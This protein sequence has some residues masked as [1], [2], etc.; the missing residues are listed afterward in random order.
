HGGAICTLVDDAGTLALI[1]KDRDSRPGVSTDLNVSFF[2]PGEGA[3]IAE[4]TVL[5]IGRTLGFVSVDIRR[6]H[7]NVLVAQGRMT[8]HMG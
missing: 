5:K 8:K 6:E 7:D 1:S 3:V 2:A 4:A